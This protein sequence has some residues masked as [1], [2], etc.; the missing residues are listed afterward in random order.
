[1]STV[2]CLGNKAIELHGAPSGS[3]SSS[4]QPLEEAV[5]VILTP[6]SNNSTSLAMTY[7]NLGATIS[8]NDIET[9]EFIGIWLDSISEDNSATH[10]GLKSIFNHLEPFQDIY[11]CITYIATTKIKQIFF[12]VSARLAKKMISLIYN[13]PKIQFI[14]IS[15]ED[16]AELDEWINQTS[17]TKFQDRVYI[18]KNLLFEQLGKDLPLP[19]QQLSNSTEEGQRPLNLFERK[20]KDSLIRN[21][22]KDSV[23]FIRYQLVIDILLRMPLSDDAKHVM[24]EYC[25]SCYKE[26]H[27]AQKHISEFEN[28]YDIDVLGEAISW[29]TR[30]CFL[31]NLL[32]KTL[33]TQDPDDLFTFRFF[34]SALHK[35]L[36]LL[37]SGR[38]QSLPSKLYSGKVL[39]TDIVEDLQKNIEG[40]VSMNGFFSTTTEPKVSNIYAGTSCSLPKDQKSVV[41]NLNIKDSVLTKPFANIRKY[42]KIQDEDEIL[43]SIG[44]VWRILD[45]KLIENEV[46]NIE[47]ELSKEDNERC[48]ELSEYLKKQIG[49]T[50]TLLTLGNFLSAIGQRE[51]AEKYYILLL[52]ELPKEHEDIGVICNNIGVIRYENNDF[53]EAVN[54]FDKARTFFASM[55]RTNPNTD[56]KLHGDIADYNQG[57]ACSTTNSPLSSATSLKYHNETIECITKSLQADH[58]SSVA[59]MINNKGLILYKQGDYTMA[60]TCYFDALKILNETNVRYPPDIS[61]VYNNI[62]ATYFKKGEHDKA[63][64]NF[65]IAIKVGLELLPSTNK[66]I[67]E[68]TTNKAAVLTYIDFMSKLIVARNQLPER[69]SAISGTPIITVPLGYLQVKNGVRPFGISFLS[70]KWNEGVLLQMKHAYERETHVRNQVR[71]KYANLIGSP[72]VFIGLRPLVPSLK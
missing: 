19:K 72:D 25:R 1:M 11:Q 50:P 46:W 39:S 10:V 68:Y 35:E 27:P 57:L 9:P 69:L 52:K 32:S 29:Y 66:W 63:L 4:F 44:T 2:V 49:E 47:L 16:K 34:I 26:E 64:E 53:C 71:P 40:L 28:T 33:S 54:W 12:I 6:P 37:N 70:R 45:V 8:K 61:V 56:N 38:T 21:L 65:D 23:A 48:I 18:D 30:P 59:I 24:S 7:H 17:Y 5:D 55:S 36:Y 58:S 31:N 60:L 3:Y 42:S 41:F 43:F 15:C 13:K 51:K 22:S 62:G 14:Y 20:D 67:T